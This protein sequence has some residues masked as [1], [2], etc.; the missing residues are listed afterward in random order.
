MAPLT[1]VSAG[2]AAGRLGRARDSAADAPLARQARAAATRTRRDKTICAKKPFSRGRARGKSEKWKVGKSEKWEMKKIGKSEK[3]ESGKT[4]KRETGKRESENRAGEGYRSLRGPR[5]RR[6]SEPGSAD[7]LVRILHRRGNR[8]RNL[9]SFKQRSRATALPGSRLGAVYFV[10]R[11]PDFPIF[12]ILSEI[13]RGLRRHRRVRQR[14]DGFRFH[15]DHPVEV[16]QFSD[17]L[18]GGLLRE[19]ESLRFK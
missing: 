2:V 15:V 11:F 3:G 18:Q 12:R 13:M 8:E 9:F 7:A 6:R 1:A 10:S 19:D 16:L 14:G 4:G 5:D 17:D